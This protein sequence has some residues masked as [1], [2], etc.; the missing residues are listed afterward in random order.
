ML[1]EDAGAERGGGGGETEVTA[2]VGSAVVDT[3]EI[4]PAA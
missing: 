1:V 3:Q 2:M 4:F